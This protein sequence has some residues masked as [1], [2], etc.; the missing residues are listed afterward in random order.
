M[1]STPLKNM[2][3]KMDSSSPS[4]GMKIQKYLSCHHLVI[5]LDNKFH[6]RT[7]TQPGCEVAIICPW[8][9]HSQ[10]FLSQGT[11]AFGVSRLHLWQVAVNN[12]DDLMA[13]W[14]RT[15]CKRC[16]RFVSR[17]WGVKFEDTEIFFRNR[18]E[19]LLKNT[20]EFLEF[21]TSPNQTNWS[22]TWRI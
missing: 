4:F 8:P 20:W 21:W 6:L 5:Q 15:S 10:Y 11:S 14:H 12:C 16:L 1:V 2:L 13:T 19:R 3:V 9:H 22:K 18:L 17:S 7:R